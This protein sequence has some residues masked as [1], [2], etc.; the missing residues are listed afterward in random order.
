MTDFDRLT[1]IEDRAQC[2][3]SGAWRQRSTDTGIIEDAEGHPVAILGTSGEARLPLGEFLAQAPVDVRWLANE[4]RTA[5]G[6]LAGARID[7]A[8]EFRVPVPVGSAGG[9]A[10]VVVRRDDQGELWAVTDGA[11]T[12]LRAWVDGGWSYV[13]DIGRAAAFRWTREG[14]IVVA[15]QVAALEA[16]SYRRA[17][18]GA[19]DTSSAGRG[20]GQ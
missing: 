13:S 8:T 20:T 5:W 10:E 7:L 14:A 1:D 4:L 9:Y 19:K 6:L 16:G 18:A 2:L 17:A 15:Q 12:G 3:P 11:L